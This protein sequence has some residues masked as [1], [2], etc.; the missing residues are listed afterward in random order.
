MKEMFINSPKTQARQ[1]QVLET[2]LEVFSEYGYRKTGMEDIASRMNLAVGTLYRYAHDKQD[3]YQKAVAYGLA[4][5]QENALLAAQKCTDPVLR[6]RTLCCSAFSY[7][8]EEPHLR[9]ILSAD[10]SL[11]PLFEAEDPFTSINNRSVKILQQF[12]QEG[13]EAKVF[14]VS[15][16]H[17]AARILFSLYHVSIQKAYVLE[18]GDEQKQ[19]EQSLDLVLYGLLTR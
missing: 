1:I 4:Q 8:R 15:N 2:A 17:A 14:S 13:V 5:W 19:F 3:L 11:F 9:R 6:F 16:A 18:T 12:I 7:L 10:P